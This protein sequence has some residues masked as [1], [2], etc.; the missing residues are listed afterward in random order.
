MNVLITGS[1]GFIGSH[2]IQQLRQHAHITVYALTRSKHVIE[3]KNSVAIYTNL[4]DANFETQLPASIDCIVHLAQSDAYREFPEKA[5]A[6]FDVNLNATQRLLNWAYKNKVKKFI[7]A[8]SGNVY[9]QQN[10]LLNETDV[11]QPEGYYGA[12]KYA[13]EQLVKA[14]SNYFEV[15]ILRIFGVYGPGQKNMTIPNIIQKI[16]NK[17]EITLAN[18][19]GLWFTPLYITD[20]AQM[21]T[22]VILQSPTQKCSV[23]NIAGNEPISLAAFIQLVA[24]HKNDK[25]HINVTVN[26]PMYLMGDASTFYKAFNF[27]P[28]TT[29]AEGL[30]KVLEHE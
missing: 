20:C 8:S 14:Y 29:L 2:T 16:K 6:I 11:C 23:Y 5:N 26:S 1:S 27:S 13:A 17:Q 25:P 28:T 7:F 22:N 30:K 4:S 15:C 10:K 3:Q 21:I 18:N 24:Q 19:Q 12:S 9:K